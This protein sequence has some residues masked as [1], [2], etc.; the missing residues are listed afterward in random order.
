MACHGWPS[1]LFKLSPALV[2][3]P[4][5]R[6]PACLCAAPPLNLPLLLIS[7]QHLLQRSFV[8]PSSFPAL[9]SSQHLHIL[10]SMG[11]LPQR[12]PTLTLPVGHTFLEALLPHHTELAKGI[13]LNPTLTKTGEMNP[14]LLVLVTVLLETLASY[15]ASSSLSKPNSPWYPAAQ[16]PSLCPCEEKHVFLPNISRHLNILI[17]SS[18]IDITFHIFLISGSFLAHLAQILKMTTELSASS[19]CISSLH[20]S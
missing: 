19:P 3:P 9:F 13:F 2:S 6:Q 12:S 10:A 18:P 5:F 1:L 17:N 14:R 7:T 20:S 15:G 11:S 8:S 4:S 16:L